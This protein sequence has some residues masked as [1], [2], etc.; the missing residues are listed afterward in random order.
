VRVAY[1]A[2]GRAPQVNRIAAILRRYDLEKDLVDVAGDFN[3]QPKSAPLAG[4]LRT[5]NLIDLLA[6]QVPD[7]CERWTYRDKSQLEF[8]V[9]GCYPGL[10]MFLNGGATP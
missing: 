7:P 10:S 6:K 3:D 2:V 9:F 5:K 8:L 4:L 1:A